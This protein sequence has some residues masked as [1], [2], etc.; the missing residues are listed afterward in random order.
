[1]K[2]LA[3][4]EKRFSEF[5]AGLTEK[6]KIGVI[7][8]DDGDGVGSAVIAS[9]VIGNVDSVC[10]YDYLHGQFLLIL[11]E[12]KKKKINKV[13]VLDLNLPEQDILELAKISEVLLID[14]H[15]FEKDLNS[16]R[17]VF[18]KSDS[19]AA[20]YMC[21]YLFSK[22]QEVPQWIASIGT[23]SDTTHRYSEQ[24]IDEFF[25]DFGFSKID[26]LWKKTFD[27]SFALIY[28]NGK[29]KAIYD[30]LMNAKSFFELGMEKYAD[31]VRKEFDKVLKDYEKNKEEHG[32]LIYYYFEPEYAIKVLVVNKLSVENYDKTFIFVQKIK[33]EDSLSF[34]ISSR[35]QSGS[36]NCPDL[37]KKAREGIPDSSSG[38]HF[39]AAGGRIPV[40]Y[41]EKFKENLIKAYKELKKE[42][43][44]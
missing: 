4:D 18:I 6:D 17:I 36:V 20:C 2:F 24:R 34:E 1:M 22:I 43:L 10:F 16:D 32:N 9:K 37:L 38:G 33:N 28:F 31:I 41:L 15:P 5:M 12:I 25:K 42:K 3:G 44:K 35:N 13:F 26:N 23:L 29:T 39:K 21:Y 30:L 27:L 11:D 8:H 40:G 14:H 19:G 7:A